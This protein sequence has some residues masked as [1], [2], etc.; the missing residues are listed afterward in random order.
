MWHCGYSIDD[1]SG[2]GGGIDNSD[3]G[4]GG[5]DGNRLFSSFFVASIN[6]QSKSQSFKDKLFDS[7]RISQ[8]SLVSNYEFTVRKKKVVEELLQ[9][10]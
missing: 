5:I 6:L 10:L 3:V 4:G 8:R 9:K 2:G 7:R 1:S